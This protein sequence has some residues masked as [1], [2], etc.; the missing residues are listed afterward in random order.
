MLH[1]L[2]LSL[3]LALTPAPPA[4]DAGAAHAAL[5]WLAKAAQ[6]QLAESRSECRARC[7][8]L[9]SQCTGSQCRAAYAA[10][11]AGCR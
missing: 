7:D 1:A 4:A 10:C 9:R 6:I 5:A 8:R 3:A 11:V 2:A